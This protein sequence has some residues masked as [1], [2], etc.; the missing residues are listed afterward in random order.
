[1]IAVIDNYDSFT[2][3]LVQMLGELGRE[4]LVLR[5][6]TFTLS[7]LA[8]KKP[9]AIVVSPG[10]GVPDDAGLSQAVIT[11]FAGRVPVLGVC[12]GHQAIGRVFG[13]EVVRAPVPVHGKSS[14]VYHNGDALFAG[15]ES[16]F[17]AG[18]YH[19]LVVCRK[20]FPPCLEVTAQTADGLIMALKH[21]TLAVYG[22]QFHPESVITPYGRIILKN[23]LGGVA[24]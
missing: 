2:Y 11:R 20:T 18:R 1:M 22:V 9:R 23:F 15:V 21:R 24:A 6:D 3:N 19:S 8:A 10:P 16:P 12:L 7:E 13:G 14:A 5:N 4:L 17:N